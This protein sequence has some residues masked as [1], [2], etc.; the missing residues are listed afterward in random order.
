MPPDQKSDHWNV[1]PQDYGRVF[2]DP[3]I[4]PV[5]LRNSLS[6]GF[7]DDLLVFC[8]GGEMPPGESGRDALWGKRWIHDYAP[9]LPEKLTDPAQ[10]E[11]IRNLFVKVVSQCGPDFVMDHL[12]QTEGSPANIDAKV[13]RDDASAEEVISL[14]YHDLLLLP[15]AWQIIR[16]GK[17]VLGEKPVIVEIGG[18]FGAMA[19][20]LKQVWPE[21]TIYLFDLPEVTAVQAYYLQA[22]FPEATLTMLEDL[23]EGGLSSESDFVLLPG[24]RMGDVQDASVDLVTNVRSMMEMTRPVIEGY[25]AEIQRVVRNGGLFACMNRYFKGNEETRFKLYPFDE[26]WQMILSQAS[27]VQPHIHELI[28]KRTEEPQHFSIASALESLP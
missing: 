16:T 19:A 8:K 11:R 6:V 2:D 4:W 18:G 10:A 15:Y 24:W 21:S 23:K 12:A 17:T 13:R 3:A 20:K 27:V 22:R 25:F 28:V 26:N 7:N 5:L 14:N 1:F 9:L